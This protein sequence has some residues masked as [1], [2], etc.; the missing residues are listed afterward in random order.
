MTSEKMEV[1]AK[2]GTRIK[3]VHER[4]VY[5]FFVPLS[6]QEQADSGSDGSDSEDNNDE[7]FLDYDEIQEVSDGGSIV[8]RSPK[9]GRLGVYTICV[10]GFC[11]SS[12]ITVQYSGS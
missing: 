10:I 2:L 4:D 3:M 8:Q 11:Y 5:G 6:R 7:E 1:V 9:K 12:I